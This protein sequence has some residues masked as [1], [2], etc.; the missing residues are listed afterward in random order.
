MAT[1]YLAG[2]RVTLDPKHV[3]GKGGEAD[4]YDIG[5]ETALKV[6]KGPQHPDYSIDPNAQ[7]AA[8]ER[9]AE[10]QEKL[11]AFPKGLPKS[12][13]APHELATSNASGGS[14]VGYSMPFLSGME[15][16]LKYSDRTY[17]ETGGIDG[18]DILE[19]FKG[20]YKTINAIHATN[21]VM[22]D[23]NDLNVLVNPRKE[24]F[25]IDADSFQFGKFLCRVFTSRFVD[26]LVCD[27]K[28][29][30]L[31]LAK[32]H[33]NGSDW[34]AYHVMLMQGLLYVDPYGGI[35]K[36]A[37]PTKRLRH[38]ERPLHRITIFHP[39]VR[40]PKPAIP[41]QVLPDD[42]LHVFVKMFVED[43]RTP[44]PLAVLEG[45]RWTKCANCGTEYA[46]GKCPTCFGATEASV[47]ETII[48]RGKVVATRIFRTSGTILCST[49]QNGKLLYLCF[50]NDSF[51]RET[52]ET[53]FSGQL[54]QEMR[55]R[56]SGPLTLV[57]KNG[58]LIALKEG[59][60]VANL[61][62]ES[63]GR[64]PMFDANAQGYY[65]LSNGQISFNGDVASQYVGSILHNQT[66]FWVGPSFGFGFY[67]AGTL[68]VAFVFNDRKQGINDQVALPPI[69]GQLFDSTCVF[70]NEHC[71]FFVSVQNAG[72][73]ENHCYVIGKN[74]QVEATAVTERGDGSWLS[75]IRGKCAAGNF[76]FCGT[77]E[78][79]VRVELQEGKLQ[80][81]Q[82]F[83]DTEPFVNSDSQLFAAKEGIYVVSRHDITHIQ[84]Q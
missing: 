5:S 35:Y 75:T 72:K 7:K 26:P 29:T 64:L 66:L 23:F 77:D 63:F 28:Q 38:D 22:G 73:I 34:Y 40:Y 82:T 79:I 17:R 59:R 48:R 51:K 65:W 11:R 30:S 2:R 21:V 19:I 47:K 84:I 67:R 14:I 42:L 27:P 8:K 46:R 49:M 56:L 10:H 45:M 1:V 36:P 39:E 78:G 60:P 41:F 9:I 44:V 12:V 33:N 15:V 81:A 3:I 68:S 13:V 55:F 24:A 32:P 4:V 70:T 52:G 57:G 43:D 71:W 16:L 37:D 31:M 25:I 6:F 18:N 50:D 20:L 54:D 83:P 61:P 58:Q 69:S 76:L 74:G 53:V 62:V 80:L